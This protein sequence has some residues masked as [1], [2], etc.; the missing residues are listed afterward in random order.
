MPVGDR[1]RQFA[2]FDA[3]KG[4]Q[5][6][7]RVKEFEH[8]MKML[9]EKSE[10]EIDEIATKLLSIQQDDYVK[11]RY[12]DGNNFGEVCG[13]IVIDFED[14]LLKIDD[15]VIKFGQIEEICK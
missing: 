8:D 5:D 4:L 13:H 14:Y 1:A 15:Q 10:K 7:L 3:L 12:F 9:G 11:V 6:A 2:P